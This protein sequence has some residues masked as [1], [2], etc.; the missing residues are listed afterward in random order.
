MNSIG[1]VFKER[2]IEKGLSVREVAEKAGISDTEVFRIESGRRKNPSA[3]ILV[4][5]G[6]VLGIANDD[7]LRFAGLKEDDNVSLIERLFP[8]LKTEKQQETAQRI[9]ASIAR[10]NVLQDHDYDDLVDH[11]VMF[12]DFRKKRPPI[13]TQKPR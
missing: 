12:L 10:Y 5:M 3:H 1:K 2:R 13:D 4:S 8:D 6:K 11:V 9:V 7:V